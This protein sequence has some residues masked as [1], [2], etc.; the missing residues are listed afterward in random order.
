MRVQNT[1]SYFPQNSQNYKKSYSKMNK[2]HFDEKFLFQNTKPKN[3]I[4]NLQPKNNPN[5]LI[6]SSFFLLKKM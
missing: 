3:H 5:T 4:N 1:F 6:M 2:F